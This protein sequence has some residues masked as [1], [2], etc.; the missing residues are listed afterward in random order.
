MTTYTSTIPFRTAHVVAVIET[1]AGPATLTLALD[2]GSLTLHSEFEEI[3][4]SLEDP[5]GPY[6]RSQERLVG[7]TAM[8]DAAVQEQGNGEYYFIKSI[9]EEA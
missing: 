7:Y 3:F 6:P 9:K 4:Y 1:E 2:P 5:F 8:I